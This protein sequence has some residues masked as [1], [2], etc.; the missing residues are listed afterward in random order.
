MLAGL[1]TELGAESRS[2]VGGLL[3]NS[4]PYEDVQGGGHSDPQGKYDALFAAILDGHADAAETVQDY[5]QGYT[6]PRAW[7]A[8]T[9]NDMV[10]RASRLFADDDISLGTL[11]S[12]MNNTVWSEEYAADEGTDGWNSQLLYGEVGETAVQLEFSRRGELVRII[13]AITY[14]V[15]DDDLN[16]YYELTQEELA[17]FVQWLYE[18]AGT[19]GSGNGRACAR[20]LGRTAPGSSFK[21]RPV[22]L[23][24]KAVSCGLWKTAPL[25]CGWTA[26]HTGGWRFRRATRCSP[27]V[28]VMKT[29][30]KLRREVSI[31]KCE[32]EERRL[33]DEL[34]CMRPRACT[35]CSLLPALWR[36]S[37]RILPYMRKAACEKCPVLPILRCAMRHGRP[38]AHAAA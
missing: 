22:C 25:C 38:C 37:E 26:A 16:S 13:S 18:Q 11:V 33:D 28:N 36:E 5:T 23:A 20:H 35:R 27:S 9:P 12:A 24:V 15:D 14:L 10:L 31:I 19:Q 2:E 30:R 3:D 34:P 17:A 7:P 1:G 4:M 32:K 8:G 21:L 6:V 29:A